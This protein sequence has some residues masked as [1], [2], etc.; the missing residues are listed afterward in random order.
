LALVY[1]VTFGGC[2]IG[3]PPFAGY[4]LSW[5]PH[6][7]TVTLLVRPVAPPAPGTICPAVRWVVYLDERIKLPHSLGAR[8]LFDGSSKP[9]RQVRA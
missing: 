2:E 9:P 3:P 5:A 7:L 6:R 1:R 8:S 4:A